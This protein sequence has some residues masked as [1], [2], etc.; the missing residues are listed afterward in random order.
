MLSKEKST[1]IV[2]EE[3]VEIK[4]NYDELEIIED[5]LL[6]KYENKFITEN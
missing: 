3:I 2:E 1:K 6:M 4:Y 5:E